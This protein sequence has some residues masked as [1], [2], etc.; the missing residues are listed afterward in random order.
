MQ[1]VWHVYGTLDF[2]KVNGIFAPV[3]FTRV[4]F[5]HL[6][7]KNSGNFWKIAK[8]EDHAER[9]QNAYR[10]SAKTDV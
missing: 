5:G 2:A 8:G 3:A 7:A 1:S 6:D 10:K 4:G 9:S